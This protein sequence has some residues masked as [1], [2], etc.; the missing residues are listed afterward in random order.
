VTHPKIPIAAEFVVYNPLAFA[1]TVN[2][3]L[4]GEIQ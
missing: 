3:T 2:E 1:L 4:K